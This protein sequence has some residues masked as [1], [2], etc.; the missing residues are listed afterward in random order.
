MD[1]P[2]CFFFALNPE[3]NEFAVGGESFQ[4]NSKPLSPT[5]HKHGEHEDLDMD[6][7]KA[8][9]DEDSYGSVLTMALQVKSH[10]PSYFHNSTFSFFNIFSR[11][12]LNSSVCYHCAI[13]H[14]K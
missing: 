9:F 2:G 12:F 5:K 8:S 10:F 14:H 3:T 4:M 11:D 6:T 13:Y 7:A 1:F